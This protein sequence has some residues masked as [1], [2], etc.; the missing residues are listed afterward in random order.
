M[1]NEKLTPA[2]LGEYKVFT[3]HTKHGLIHDVKRLVGFVYTG[4]GEIIRPCW[5]RVFTLNYLLYAIIVCH[6][7]NAVARER[8]KYIKVLECYGGSYAVYLSGVISDG[9]RARINYDTITKYL[10]V[11]PKMDAKTLGL[12]PWVFT[13]FK[14]YLMFYLFA[15]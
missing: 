11:L 3:R 7:F 2:S 10:N 14:H 12:A 1:E 15:N 8:F 9:V 4:R 5:Q 6:S 13:D